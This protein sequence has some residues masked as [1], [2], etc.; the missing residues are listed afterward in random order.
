MEDLLLKELY[1]ILKKEQIKIKEP[2]SQHTSLR[3]G[4]EAD[5]MVSLLC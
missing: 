5:Y 2:M 1:K 4:G 3:I